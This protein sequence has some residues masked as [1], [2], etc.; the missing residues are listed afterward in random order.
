MYSGRRRLGRL[1]GLSWIDLELVGARGFEPPTTCTPCR[2]A[3]RLRYA[4]KTRSISERPWRG[5]RE[6]A[7]SHAARVIESA[8]DR[9]TVR[10]CRRCIDPW[11]DPLVDAAARTAALPDRA[12]CKGGKCARPSDTTG[13]LVHEISATQRTGISVKRRAG[14]D[15]T[16]FQ[17]RSNAI[18]S[19][20]ARR[21]PS[22]PMSLEAAGAAVPLRV[23]S[24]KPRSRR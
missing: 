1:L 24:P 9:C 14:I 22:T 23:G 12:R 4:P 13:G 3:T 10:R 20:M 2:Y 5:Q 11:S 7:L 17:S 19:E 6:A 16:P 15:R 8:N 18:T 21:R